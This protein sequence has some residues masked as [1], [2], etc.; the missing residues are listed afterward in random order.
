MFRFFQKGISLITFYAFSLL[1]TTTI[2]SNFVTYPIHFFNKN[3][4]IYFVCV[5][6]HICLLKI[7][8]Y[9]QYFTIMR[10]LVVLH[11]LDL[12]VL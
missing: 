7:K 10:L 11:R 1:N 4:L 9:V 2:I 8:F 3:R 5:L 6:L 12:M